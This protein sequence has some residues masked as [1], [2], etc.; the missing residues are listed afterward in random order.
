MDNKGAKAQR[1]GAATRKGE[2]IRNPGE[3]ETGRRQR[4]LL[5]MLD[6]WALH[7]KDAKVELTTDAWYGR[8]RMASGRADGRM[9]RFLRGG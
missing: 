6:S 5:K 4:V 8:R 3:E 1:G 2:I 7:C 9:S